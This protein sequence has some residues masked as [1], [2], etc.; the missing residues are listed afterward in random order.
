MKTNKGNRKCKKLLT[1]NINWYFLL[2]TSINIYWTWAGQRLLLRSGHPYWE[3]DS[4]R[5]HRPSLALTA[6][7]R[8]WANQPSTKGSYW[9]RPPRILQ[10]DDGVQAGMSTGQWDAAI[11]CQEFCL[12]RT[13]SPY[14]SSIT[15]IL[16]L[17][18]Q[19]SQSPTHLNPSTPSFQRKMKSFSFLIHY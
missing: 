1:L 5:P 10:Q 13:E 14:S 12:D 8:P 3:A 17:C 16:K 11:F 2:T 6:G 15:E 9:W 18:R 4:S 19:L 7:R